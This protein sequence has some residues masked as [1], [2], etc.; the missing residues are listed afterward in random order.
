MRAESR[1]RSSAWRLGNE[2][3][4]GTPSSWVAVASLAC[5]HLP[6]MSH[7]YAEGQAR[8]EVVMTD[9]NEGQRLVTEFAGV[10]SRDIVV[11][12]LRDT[13]KRWADA[14]V[15]MY[16]GLLSERFARESLRAAA[17]A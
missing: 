10:F 13:A 15:Q 12:C 14:P 6:A 17:H 16:V 4:S 8:K 1:V 9:S 5:V 2:G 7:R 3:Q 11:K